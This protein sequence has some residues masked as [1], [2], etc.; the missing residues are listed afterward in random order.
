MAA[1]VRAHC[2]GSEVHRR[3]RPRNPRR[4]VALAS[5][6]K[7]TTCYMCA[8]RCGIRV[9]LRDGMVRYIDGNPDHPIN[10]GVICA[11]GA[12]GIMK[13]Y[14]PARLTQPLMRKPGARAATTSS[15]RSPGTRRSGV[16]EERLAHDPR[17][18]P[19][20]VRALHRA[21]PD[22][23]AHRPLR[24]PVRH[25]ELRGARRVL[26]G[27][28]G[29]RHDLHDRRLVLGVRR[30]RPR[31]REAVRDARH[32][33]GPPLEPAEDR[34]LEVQARRWQVRLD[35]PGPHRLLRDRRRVGADPA[36]HRRRAA[37]RAHPRDHRARPLRPRLPGAL[38]QR[39]TAREP[40]RS[41]RPVRVARALAEGRRGQRAVS[42]EPDLVGP[43]SRTG[44]CRRTPKARTRTC[45]ASS[46]CPTARPS[47]RRS[48]S[49]RSG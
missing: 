40:R 19:E 6:V 15:S 1:S 27:E 16:L 48:S 20:E 43:P 14:S 3:M 39:R 30:T 29:D 31:A 13:Q 25:A 41:E 21:R 44:R 18:R 36:G 45:S 42:A 34:D 28:H 17:H 8:C 26:L 37:A 7:T 38:H 46:G 5:E 9:H 4:S 12:S 49:S 33:R 47:S 24:A 22:A 32:R 23:G 2:F 35:Q 11:K 10:Q